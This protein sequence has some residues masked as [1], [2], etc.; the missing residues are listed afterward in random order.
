MAVMGVEADKDTVQKAMMCI[1]Y[2]LGII[3]MLGLYGVIQERVMS[4]P[5]D[6]EM[7]KTSVF[8]VLCNRL[9]AILY[10][11]LMVWQ[12]GEEWG[13]KA[14]LW[15][16]LAISLS[17]VAATS[18]QYEALKWVSF[19]VQM[20]GKSFKMMPVILWSIAISGKKYKAQDWG[21][22]AGVTFGVTGFLMTGSIGS[23]HADKGTS[24][25]GLLLLL[26]FLGCDGFTSTFQ[27]KLFSEH[28]TSKYNQMVYTNLGSA[29][30]SCLSL[31]AL[32]SNGFPACFSFIA[33]H[34]AFLTHAMVLS[35]AAVSGQWFIYSQVKEFGALVFAATMNLRQVI[36]ICVSYIMYGH[37]ITFFQLLGLCCVFGAL[38]YKSYLGFMKEKESKSKT[39]VSQTDDSVEMGKPGADTVGKIAAPDPEEGKP[40]VN[41][42]AS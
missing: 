36:S 20:L 25:Y 35:A 28:K 27:E 22:A 26:G 41:E 4:M 31:L 3:V 40:M 15:K 1:V 5:Y 8:L 30:I 29:A 32:G 33:R 39:P 6:G 12:K 23:K 9:W 10:A 24:F 42:R 14:P 38:F 37:H 11:F 18:C 19:P 7:F 16:Y 13:N 34:P 17:N 2:G 21:I